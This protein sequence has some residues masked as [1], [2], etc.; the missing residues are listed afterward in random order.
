M[1]L[2]LGKAVILCI[3]VLMAGCSGIWM[4]ASHSILLDE[5][6]A[7]SADMATRSD[8]GE[9]DPNDCKAV[10]KQNAMMW[11]SFK[12]AKDAPIANQLISDLPFPPGGIIGTVIR[13]DDI[14]I[15]RGDTVILPGDEV[16]VFALPEA[17]PEIE[18]LFD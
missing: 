10:I 4:D 12:V 1:K 14:L 9:L 17:L 8:A 15:P 18:K 2:S 11:Q 6:A 16:I 13:G 5:T 3:C 7:W